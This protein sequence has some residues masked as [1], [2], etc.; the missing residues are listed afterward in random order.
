MEGQI[1]VHRLMDEL[2]AILSERYDLIIKLTLRPK[3][4]KEE[5][6]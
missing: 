1:D 6:A 4:A 2:S 3:D 5:S